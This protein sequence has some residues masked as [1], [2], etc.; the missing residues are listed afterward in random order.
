[1][2]FFNKEDIYIGYSIE[3]LSKVRSSL[4]NQGIKYTYKVINQSDQWWELGQGTSRG[5]LGSFGMF[6]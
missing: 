1:M 2:F 5:N 4:K 6:L 3:E